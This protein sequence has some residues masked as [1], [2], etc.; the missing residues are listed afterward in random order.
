MARGREVLG[1]ITSLEKAVVAL[2]SGLLVYALK[3]S[4]FFA[5]PAGRVMP[6]GG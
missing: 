6:A 4:L 3:K 5:G 2:V 1:R